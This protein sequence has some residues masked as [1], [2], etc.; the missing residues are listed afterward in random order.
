MSVNGVAVRQLLK[1]NGCE[2]K[3]AAESLPSEQLEGARGNLIDVDG[4]VFNASRNLRRGFSVKSFFIVD[5]ANANAFESMVRGRGMKADFSKGLELSN[6]L[7]PIEELSTA[8]FAPSVPTPDG[9]RGALSISGPGRIL[10]YEVQADDQY[11]IVWTERKG[12]SFDR[13]AV[14]DDG[15]I[16]SSGVAGVP[17]V[18]MNPNVAVSDLVLD[19]VDSGLLYDVAFLPYRA[20]DE[21]MKCMTEDGSAFGDFPEILV[22]GELTSQ[23]TSRALAQEVSI[24]TFEDR[25][26]SETRYLYKLTFKIFILNDEYEAADVVSPEVVA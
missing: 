9:G 8:N 1:V 12:A 19:S 3:V 23:K 22:S 6:S 20:S 14:R 7:P 4:K 25:R 16:W 15:L 18:V 5:I 10:T 24:E 11:T 13:R 21:Q 17:P 26:K 2:I